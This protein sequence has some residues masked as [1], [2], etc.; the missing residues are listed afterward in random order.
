MRYDLVYT[1]LFLAI[2]GTGK[3]NAQQL[4][5]HIPFLSGNK[6]GYCDSNMNVLIPP[7]WDEALFF[8]NNNA[9]VRVGPDF[10]L[11][12]TNGKYVIPPG[13]HWNG[14]RRE[15]S[16]KRLTAYD[17]KGKWSRYDTVI[18]ACENNFITDPE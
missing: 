9:T 2:T 12:D 16:Y 18:Y 13:Q 8:Y 14:V 10:C 3:L 11:I 15:S 5:R 6:Y 7:Q 4:P 17:P 1:S